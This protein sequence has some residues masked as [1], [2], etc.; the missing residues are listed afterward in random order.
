[1]PCEDINL[2]SAI[3]LSISALFMLVGAGALC[4]TVFI[5]RIVYQE[6]IENADKP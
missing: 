6:R 4:L 5:W 2:L 1:M 3:L